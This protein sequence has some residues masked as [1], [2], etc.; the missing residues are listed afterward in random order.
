[1]RAWA[2]I[3]QDSDF[4]NRQVQVVPQDEGGPP[5]C[6]K[7]VQHLPGLVHLRRQRHRR[8]VERRRQLQSAPTQVRSAPVNHSPIDVAPRVVNPIPL[9]VRRYEGVLDYVLRS[10]VGASDQ[11][12]QANQPWEFSSV[13]DPKLLGPGGERI[14][15]RAISCQL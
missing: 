2:S 4:T 8:L 12:S 14:I 9:P 6:W 15:G 1:D 5:S 13:D 11:M 10:R 7:T 3:H